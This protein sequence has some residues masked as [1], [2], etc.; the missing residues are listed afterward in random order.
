MW[1]ISMKII[2]IPLNFHRL[3]STQHTNKN[4]TYRNQWILLPFFVYTM[5]SEKAHE[6]KKHVMK[7]RENNNSFLQ[8]FQKKKVI[9]SVSFGEECNYF[10][11]SM[12]AFFTLLGCCIHTLSHN[13]FHILIRTTA[14]FV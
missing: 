13:F 6:K 1:N 7:K 3:S 5:A 2:L 12:N 9:T 10:E 11:I 8:H 14:L 4:N